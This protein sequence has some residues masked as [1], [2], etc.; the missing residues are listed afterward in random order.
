[1]DDGRGKPGVDLRYMTPDEKRYFYTGL[2]L[3]VFI[4]LL[5]AVL[6]LVYIW[7]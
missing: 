2:G 3:G 1:M 6:F 5:P 4:G 7:P